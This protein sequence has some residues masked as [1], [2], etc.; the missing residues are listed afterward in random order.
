MS[1]FGLGSRPDDRVSTA[2]AAHSGSASEGSR[3]PLNETSSSETASAAPLIRLRDLEHEFITDA[4]R[5]KVLKE[6]N[7]EILP[8]ELTMLVGPSGCG[9]TTLLC[10]A[11]GLLRHT[12]GRVEVLGSDA[13]RLRGGDLVRLRLAGIGFVFQQYNLI[14]ALSATENAAIPLVGAGLSWAKAE[15]KAAALLERLDMGPHRRKLPRQLS[16]GQQQRVSIARALVHEPRLLLCDEPTAA[17]DSASG[18]QV[19]ELLRDL[20]VHPGRAALVVTHDPR[21][22][23]FADRIVRMED[24]RIIGDERPPKDVRAA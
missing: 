8:G 13:G 1:M 21:I 18:H 17:L 24:G 10:V 12:A 9:K 20:A 2:A 11:A 14:P 19:L 22:Y 3:P 4:G 5:L 23:S 6:I 15:A 16:G 7:L